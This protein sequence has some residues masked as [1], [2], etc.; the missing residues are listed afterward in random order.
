MKYGFV[1]PGGD[2]LEHLEIAQEIE[3]A[4]WDGVFLGDA[5]YWM[6]PW[7]SLAGI[8]VRTERVRLGPLLTPVSRRRPWKLASE[9]MTLDRL[10]GG[11]VILPVGLGAVDTGFAQVGEE[12]DRRVR[13]QLLDE[14]LEVVERF[15]SGKPFSYAGDH[16]KVEWGGDWLFTP[17][18]QPR[19]PVWVVGVWGRKASMRRALRWDGVLASKIGSDGLFNSPTADDVRSIREYADVNRS[20]STPFDIVVEGITPTSDQRS[21]PSRIK[22]LAD[23]GATWWIE[24]MWEVPGGLDAVLER[25]RLGPPRIAAAH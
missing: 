3:A 6:D 5:V 15:W 18:Q 16:Y 22:P 10:S 25:V 13:A 11:R 2:V 21:W 9:T 17:V 12:T 7:V 14:G 8:A 4:G 1:I 19:I 23:A 24:S 20:Q